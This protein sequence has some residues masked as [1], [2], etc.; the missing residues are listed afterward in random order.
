MQRTKIKQKEAGIGRHF[1]IECFRYIETSRL[2][3]WVFQVKEHHRGQISTLVLVGVEV[4]GDA[5]VRVVHHV[6][7]VLDIGG[8]LSLAGEPDDPAHHGCLL[9]VGRFLQALKRIVRM[10]K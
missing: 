3:L 9:G 5:L 10:A 6:P 2:T 4:V 7:K 8:V 1:K